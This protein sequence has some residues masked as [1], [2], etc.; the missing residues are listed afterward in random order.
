MC[1]RKKR[2]K[3]DKNER[4]KDQQRRISEKGERPSVT[5]SKELPADREA[6]I[7]T[8]VQALLVAIP[9]LFITALMKHL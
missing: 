5:G 2:Y 3:K 6:C 7:D 8:Q 4:G 9:G 1:A